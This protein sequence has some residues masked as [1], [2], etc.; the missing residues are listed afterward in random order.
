MTF[1]IFIIVCALIL[2]SDGKHSLK[3]VVILSRHNLRTPL[4]KDLT[5]LTPKP[6]PHWRE[7]RGYLT[8]KGAHLEGLMGRYFSAWLCKEEILHKDCPTEDMFYAY[9]NAKQRTRASAESFVKNAFPNCDVKVHYEKE[10]DPV[11]NPVIHNI[12]TKFMD[13]ALKQM[14]KRLDQLSLNNSLLFME[15]ILDYKDSEQCRVENKCDLCADKNSINV[16]VGEKPNI[17]G[18]I[19]VAKSA[20]DSFVMSYYEGFPIKDVAWDFIDNN[21]KWELIME[22]SK[23]YHDVIFNTTLVARDIAAPLI[24]YMTDIFTNAEETPRVTL[25]MGHDANVLTMLNS[26]EF[27]TFTL[28]KQFEKSPVGG[29]IVFQKWYD[30]KSKKNLLKIDYVYQSMEQLRNGLN[31]SLDKPPQFTQLEL[32]SCPVDVNG[33][34]LWDDFLLFLKSIVGNN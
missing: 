33:F 20:I 22:I 21:K 25:I 5:D 28:H 11:F 1:K 27:K 30:N 4:S 12:T 7:K 2:N 26:M 24:K 14:N 15:N 17:S 18:P 29:K 23:G 3:Q 31:L 9:A 19:K 16:A 34:C 8:A 10:S 13:V 32:T 6:W